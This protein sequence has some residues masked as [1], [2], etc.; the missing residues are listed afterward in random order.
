MMTSC[1]MLAASGKQQLPDSTKNVS[2]FVNLLFER[3]DQSEN[4]VGFVILMVCVLYNR[5]ACRSCVAIISNS[6]HFS[7]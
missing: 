6:I 1:Y 2:E 4:D 3:L 5:R 7:I